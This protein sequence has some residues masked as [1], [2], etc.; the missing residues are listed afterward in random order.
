MKNDTENTRWSE[1]G[2]CHSVI[3]HEDLP[4]ELRAKRLWRK[5]VHDMGRGI[6]CDATYQPAGQIKESLD[7]RQADL[8]DVVII[9][10]HDLPLFF[11]SAAQWLNDWLSA[12]ST[13]P[14]ALFVL[15]DGKP[16]CQVVSM[17]RRLTEFAGVTLFN[18]HHETGATAHGRRSDEELA[19]AS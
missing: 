1:K 7:F 12:H 13:V 10:V 3:V 17:L 19:L 2:R 9:S 6:R 18:R 11:F 8:T 14:R 5:L 4:T 15:H 16:D